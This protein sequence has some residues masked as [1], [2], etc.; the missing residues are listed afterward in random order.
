MKSVKNAANPWLFAGAGLENLWLALA[1]QNAKMLK[2]SKKIPWALNAPFAK[3]EMRL[4]GKPSV[5]GFFTGVQNILNAPLLLGRNPMV[6][7]AA[8]VV[9]P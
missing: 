1:S 9:N 3:K 2:I 7:F 5:A 6:N 4:Q 8:N